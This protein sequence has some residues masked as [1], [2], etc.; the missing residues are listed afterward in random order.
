MKNKTLSKQSL[1]DYLKTGSLQNS[2]EIT[3]NGALNFHWANWRDTCHF[4]RDFANEY[5]GLKR[6]HDLEFELEQLKKHPVWVRNRALTNETNLYDLYDFYSD[7]RVRKIWFEREDETLISLHSHSGPYVALTSMRW[8]DPLI[9]AAFIYRKILKGGMP[10]RNFRLG[11]HIPVLCYFD[12]SP[13]NAPLLYMHQMTKDGII[14]KAQG[15]F[16][17]HRFLNSKV[18]RLDM[19]LSPFKKALHRN[20][21]DVLGEI[22]DTDFLLLNKKGKDSFLLSSK[23]MH[24][25]NNLENA[26]LTDGNSF[27]IFASYDDLIQ[28]K[29]HVNLEEVLGGFTGEMEKYF[30]KLLKECA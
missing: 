29:G 17:L 14:F 24:L 21:A 22:E 20:I 26:K 5:K 8:L 16:N 9:Y 1:A 11:L 7:P 12:H 18:I 10:L 30:K 15:N 28:H 6:F 3:G 4:E 2:L 13:I 27:Y 23:I 25:H 19:D